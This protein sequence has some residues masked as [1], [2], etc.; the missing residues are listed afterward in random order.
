MLA[1]STMWNALKQ[2]D[3]AALFDELKEPGFEVIALSRHLTLEQVEQLKPLLRDI[4]QMSPYFIQNF[5]PILPGIPPAEAENDI[6]F[7]EFSA[8]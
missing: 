3:G 8:K 4:G 7:R 6:I 2:P 5:C 1:I